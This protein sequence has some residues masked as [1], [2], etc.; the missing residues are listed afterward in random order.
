MLPS[1]DISSKLLL[2]T[3]R[4]Y[5]PHLLLSTLVESETEQNIAIKWRSGL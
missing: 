5:K 2:E 1:L 4:S 3:S